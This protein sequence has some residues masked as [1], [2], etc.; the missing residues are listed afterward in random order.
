MDNKNIQTEEP[1]ARSVSSATGTE[2]LQRLNSNS[3]S[4]GVV[5]S[6]SVIAHPSPSVIVVDKATCRQVGCVTKVWI[7]DRKNARLSV[8]ARRRRQS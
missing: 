6:K 5:L 2:N 1:W 4:I 7:E 8:L 3:W